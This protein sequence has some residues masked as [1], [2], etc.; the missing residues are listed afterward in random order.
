MLR[1]L[2]GEKKERLLIISIA[3]QSMCLLE[4]FSSECFAIAS[5]EKSLG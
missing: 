5:E 1:Y 2:E 3:T 4:N